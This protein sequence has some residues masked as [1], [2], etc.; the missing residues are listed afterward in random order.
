MLFTPTPFQSFVIGVVLFE[1]MASSILIFFQL[2]P[3]EK[4]WFDQFLL[5]YIHILSH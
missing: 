1:T 4:Y 5:T 2:C 3:F